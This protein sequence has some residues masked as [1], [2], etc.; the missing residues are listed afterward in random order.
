MKNRFMTAL[1]FGLFGLSVAFAANAEMI[2]IN[3]EKWKLSEKG[4]E[5]V[6]HAGRTALKLNRGNAALL[7]SN[8]ENGIIS[9]DVWMQEEPGFGGV[10]F[11]SNDKNSENFYL[12]PHLNGMPDA[13]QYMPIFNN[14]SS[15]QIFHG[16]RYSAPTQ[17][18][19]G[20]WISVKLAIKGDKMD[21][22]LD[23]DKPV[24]HVDNLLLDGKA[25]GI[26]FSAV[27][28]D[29][30]FSNVAVTPTDD[31]I[32][33]GEAKPLKE[34][35]PGQITA[36]DV[37]TQ[38]VAARMI[39]GKAVLDTALLEGQDWTRL[40]VTET[41]AI[42]L[43]EVIELSRDKNTA[44]VRL[45]ITSDKAQ[46]L[47]LKYGFSDRLTLFLNGKAIAHE[48]DRYMSRDYRFLGTVGLFDS[49]YLPL[50]AGENE[51]IFAV[52]EAF[53]GWA[54]LAAAEQRRGI[55]IK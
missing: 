45:R 32:L 23:S 12:R 36:F 30:Y 24:L 39:E 28:T 25:G 19:Y 11:R 2:P 53:G 47:P 5:I 46:T 37:A 48:D 20:N 49:V 50:K 34:P 13:N 43:S 14:G 16:E 51:V 52:T 7:G 38:P 54:L 17:Y 18:N 35:A 10:Y 22:Y 55:T 44:L 26:S 6:E 29:F 9:F 1:T 33:T 41:G 42:N 27:R 3:A 4:A 21:V 8:F 40:N 15:W 31:V